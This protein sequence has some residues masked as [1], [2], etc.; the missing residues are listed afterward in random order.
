MSE[1]ESNVLE[2]YGI[3]R[4]SGRYPWGSGNNAIQRA[5]DFYQYIDKMVADGYS[6]TEIAEINSTPHERLTATDLKNIRSIAKEVRTTDMVSRAVALKDKGTKGST[7]AREMG[8]PESTYRS[9]IKKSESN[10]ESALKA[11]ATVLQNHVDEKG[12]LD[13]S[14][15]TA[16]QLGVT[17]TK[18][19]AAVAYLRDLGYNRYL[20]KVPQS[21]TSYET[22]TLVLTKP[23]MTWRQAFDQRFDVKT[24]QEWS[25]DG[26]LSYIG[27]QDPLSIDSKRIQFNYKED[28]GDKAD[29][30]M[31]VRPGVKDLDMGASNYAQVR[32][33][34]DGTHYLKGMAIKKADLPPG[35]D[36][37]FNTPKSR[38]DGPENAMKE[39]KNDP[40]NPFGATVRQIVDPQTK[41][42]TSAL[43]IVNEEGNWDDWSRSF[44]SQVLSKQPISLIRSQ[45]R[46]TVEAH[47]ADLNEI[48]SI[49]NQAVKKK[50]LAEYAEQVDGYATDLRAIAMPKQRTQV[51]L[52]VPSMNER[53]IYAPN[54]EHGSRV[55]LVRFPH[56]G[57]F[58]IPELVVNNNQ[59]AAKKLLGNAKDAVGISH[60]VAEK[61]SGAD[62]DG[63]TVLV[64][65]ND[66][67]SIKSTP[68]L[69]DLKDF[70][71]KR[72]YAES[73]GMKVMTKANTG[74]EM[75]MITN[76]ITDMQIQ[77]ATSAEVA[78][79]VKHSMVV[80]D[81][82]KHRLDYTRSAKENGIAALKEKYQG[83]AQKGASTLLSLA[84]AK[85]H[86]PERRDPKASLG[87]GPL[88]DVETGK[89]RY[90]ETGRTYVNDKGQTVSKKTKV[91]RLADTDDAHTLSSGL[92]V[93]VVYADHANRMKALANEA[94]RLSVVEPNHKRNPAM[95]AQYRSEVD[96][97]MAKYNEAL[98]TKPLDR[99]A[100]GIA[101]QQIRAKRADNPSL[102]ADKEANDKMKTQA[103]ARARARLGLKPHS[104]TITDSEWN[105]I[106]KGAVSHTLLTKI[107]AY[108]DMKE[109]RQRSMPRANTVVT[110]AIASKASS[111]LA[112]GATPSAVATALGI[113]ISTLKSAIARGEV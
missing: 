82:E 22:D 3:L 40:D 43:N 100:Q 49:T 6:L 105:A 87:E 60:K 91:K 80:I 74:K 70:D 59:R 77:K 83:G 90:V 78:R 11:T 62:F 18:L 50:L 92:A 20:L 1:Q 97:L 10:K 76:L 95:A 61:L 38:L 104:I 73:P 64:I 34:V 12:I 9:L 107:L 71:A 65:P 113:P 96:S 35:I 17:D 30:V 57:T 4:L 112:G 23:D 32:I 111:M 56:G 85:E 106:Q 28:G 66:S 63:D 72:Q 25:D 58:E 33:L 55:A 31:Y 75:G 89:K 69:K 52:P 47:V 101:Q 53:E 81:A 67:G 29:G 14:L 7:A 19:K 54:F 46:K 27:I 109:V 16:Q 45:L 2:H 26:G 44:A 94:R 15:G 88:V 21:T 93:E 5:N 39:I 102:Y 86:V 84:T 48:K 79:A 103:L 24:I 41:K 68:G 37:V 99:R 98:K 42:V 13:I 51:I 36:I 110:S 108:T 8:I